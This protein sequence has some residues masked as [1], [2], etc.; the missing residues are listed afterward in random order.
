MANERVIRFTVEAPENYI[1]PLSTESKAYP[2]E[3]SISQG[4]P[5]PFNP[6]TNFDLIIPDREKVR[7]FI[8][9]ILGREVR[10]LKNSI[11]N[12][13]EY[14]LSW[15]GTD[16]FGRLVSSGTYFVVSDYSGIRQMQKLLF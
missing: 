14:R 2:S 5:N 7:I 11:L 4:Y 15:D 8:I 3:F 9:D 13:G 1:A 10:I 16:K 6:K 12:P